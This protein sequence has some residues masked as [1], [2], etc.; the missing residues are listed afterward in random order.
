MPIRRLQTCCHDVLSLELIHSFQQ[1]VYSK[2]CF[3]QGSVQRWWNHHDVLLLRSL[4]WCVEEVCVHCELLIKNSDV[5]QKTGYCVETF[6]FK[7]WCRSVFRFDATKINGKATQTSTC[8]FS[9]YYE[10]MTTLWEI[11]AI[12]THWKVEKSFSF[13]AWVPMF[14]FTQFWAWE[15][16]KFSC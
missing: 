2:L 9:R 10:S 16:K 15:A 11:G 5:N 8:T 7:R 6:L 13:F 14:S 12:K 1:I 3:N 4:N